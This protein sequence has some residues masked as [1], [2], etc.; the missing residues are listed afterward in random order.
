MHLCSI[1]MSRTFQIFEKDCE[2]SHGKLGKGL[3]FC[4]RKLKGSKPPQQK[5]FYI[6]LLVN[7][8]LNFESHFVSVNENTF[9]A[10]AKENN[11]L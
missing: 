10:N 8:I 11:N 4:T 1:R 3:Y 7:M 9:K 2:K 6:L 5:Q